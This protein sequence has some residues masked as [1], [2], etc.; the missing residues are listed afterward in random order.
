MTKHTH[1][2][3]HTN[4]TDYKRGNDGRFATTSGTA[5]FHKQAL[6]AHQAAPSNIKANPNY[7]HHQAASF[8]HAQAANSLSKARLA[9]NN[10]NAGMASSK[11]LEDAQKHADNATH[12]ESQIKH[13][14]K[15]KLLGGAPW[16]GSAPLHPA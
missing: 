3:I 13:H 2:H 15:H 10:P 4:D 7:K 12:H 5:S 8:S 6:G 11:W 9:H 16:D 1:I 14:A